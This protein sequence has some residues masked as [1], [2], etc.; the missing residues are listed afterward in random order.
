[1][2]RFYDELARLLTEH[3]ALVVATLVKVAGSSP[4]NQGA[5][6]VVLP[7]GAIVGTLGGGG[8]EA[9]VVNDAL[10]CLAH[11]T[12][13]L[14][15]YTLSEDALQ[16]KCGGA[17]EVYLEPICPPDRLVV[18][19]GGHVGKAIARQAPSVGFSVTVVDD[20]EEHLSPGEYPAGTQLART[21]SAFLEGFEPPGP[22]DFVVVVTRQADMDAD[23]A[24]RHAGLC[25]YVGVMGSLKKREFI[26]KRLTEAGLPNERFAH[27]RCPMGLDIGSDTPEEIAVS[28]VAEMIAVRAQ[29]RFHRRDA[30]TQRKE[31]ICENKKTEEK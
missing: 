5:K 17:V 30:E 29:K 12:S 23:L 7:D 21:D 20:R 3:S 18:F 27:M 14:K 2:R 19:G 9:Q 10:E 4:R 22:C 28:V 6:M 26:R 16:M 24:G 25:A 1:M 11:R 15:A 8:L 13:A 31:G